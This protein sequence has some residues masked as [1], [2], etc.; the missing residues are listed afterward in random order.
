MNP[1]GVDR[2]D[3]CHGNVD[4]YKKTVLQIN[5]RDQDLSSVKFKA[6]DFSEFLDEKINNDAHRMDVIDKQIE[7]KLF[8]VDVQY[9]LLM[10]P[11]FFIQ[12][13]TNEINLKLFESV[14]ACN[15]NL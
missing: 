1:L 7:L 2:I 6:K 12:D 3:L 14:F 11:D 15:L 13:S 10:D 8:I 5:N 4:S 9:R